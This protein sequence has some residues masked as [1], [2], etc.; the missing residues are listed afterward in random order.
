MTAARPYIPHGCD[1]QGRLRTGR[2]AAACS[3]WCQLEGEA[4]NCHPLQPA[5]ACTELGAGG[6]APRLG[7]LRRAVIA[8]L[9]DR[10]ITVVDERQRY[11]A[12]GCVGPVYQ[13]NSRQQQLQLMQHIRE[14]Q[15]GA[16]LKRTPSTLIVALVGAVVLVL[17]ACGGGGSDQPEPDQPTPRV[18]CQAR[19]EACK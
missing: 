6:E 15:A 8:G 12:A 5:E 2:A 11:E 3:G 13:R 19:P 7:L 9:Q 16:P 10:C 1:Q 17:G 14:L 4:C 18:D